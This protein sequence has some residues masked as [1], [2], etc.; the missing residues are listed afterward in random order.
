MCR[1]KQAMELVRRH[2]V[3]PNIIYDHR[4]PTVTFL[5]KN[6]Y[7]RLVLF[8]FLIDASFSLAVL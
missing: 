1:Y 7:E 5:R 8:L 2:R 3:D 4:S 6:N